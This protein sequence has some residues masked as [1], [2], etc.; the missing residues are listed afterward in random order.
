MRTQS[1]SIQ[2]EEKDSSNLEEA[3]KR[4]EDLSSL[5]LPSSSSLD[6]EKVL[7]SLVGEGSVEEEVGRRVDGLRK[8]FSDLTSRIDQSLISHAS[9]ITE[10]GREGREDQIGEVDA[11][12]RKVFIIV[13]GF[14]KIWCMV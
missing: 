6:M 10:R 9:L 8:S 7:E 2:K 5:P 11:L 14:K 3:L 1:T 12:C 13:I 4:A